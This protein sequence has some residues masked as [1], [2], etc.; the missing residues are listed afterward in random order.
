M[1]IKRII[2]ALAITTTALG[3]S[4]KPPE[5]NQEL[6]PEVSATEVSQALLDAQKGFDPEKDYRVNDRGVVQLTSR[7]FASSAVRE[8]YE[9]QVT[10]VNSA[11][12]IYTVL[13]KNTGGLV[14]EK[15]VKE[16]PITGSTVARFIK[17]A[18]RKI[19]KLVSAIKISPSTALGQVTRAAS[20]GFNPP[21]SIYHRIL[22][23][24]FAKFLAKATGTKLRPM[25]ASSSRYYGL[26][27][28]K[29]KLLTSNC[30][31]VVDCRVNATR[32]EFDEVIKDDAGND[33]RVH[34]MYEISVEVPGLFVYMDECVS[35]LVTQEES[36]Y[37]LTEC[38]HV[39]DFVFGFAN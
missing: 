39:S 33:K 31:Q 4:I 10:T 36:Q 37:P 25:A 19:T 26:K 21:G 29:H 34:R 22:D 28:L 9:Y 32:V 11:E 12:I 8:T 2:A 23:E 17:N 27:I 3:C 24:H 1:K 7:V 20:T 18:Y 14:Q 13:N 30:S 38:I 5:D 16:Q 15:I 35:A 6:G